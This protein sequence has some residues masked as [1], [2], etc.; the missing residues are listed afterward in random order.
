MTALEVRGLT[1]RLDGRPVLR[2]VDLDVGTGEVHALVGFNGA[3]KS[4]LMRAALGML[5]P[6]AG[7]V[8][9]LGT[10]VAAADAA[11]W[12]H[13]GHLVDA[14]LAYPEL[15]V[16]ENLRVAARLR[17]VPAHGVGDA[18][19]RVVADL[20]LEPWCGR[21]ARALSLGNRQRLGLAGA[22]VH[23]PRLLVLDEPANALDPSGVVLLRDL[24]R[25]AVGRGAAVL[26]SSHHL[27]EVARVAHRVTVIHSGTVLGEL[28]PHGSDLEQAFFAL[29]YAAD[30]E[31]RSGRGPR[32]TR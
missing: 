8:R 26:V 11:T 24:L 28:D 25:D 19:D 12:R 15:T 21:R 2:D 4:C 30:Q 27:D 18:V 10:P 14:P 22:M 23:R 13:V 32:S 20:E 5:R 1:H 17:G 6:D 29:A 3:G 31:A 7:S 16:H 9:V